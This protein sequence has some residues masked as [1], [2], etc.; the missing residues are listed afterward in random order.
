MPSDLT[1]RTTIGSWLQLADP[2][3]TEIM[4]RSGFDWLTIDLE[5]TSTTLAQAAEMIR[6]GSLAGVPMFA[7]ISGH[8]TDQIKRLLDMGVSGIIA[9]DVR[10]A[11]DAERLAAACFYPPRG[12]R[13]VGLARAQGY[14]RSFKQ[15]LEGSAND[16]VF[17]PQIEHIGAVD[18]LDGILD[19]DGVAGFFVGPYDLSGSLGLPGQFDH[20]DVQAALD[21]VAEFIRPTGP[22]AGI[23]VVDPDINQLRSAIKRGYRFI[24]FASEMLIFSE[25]MENLASGVQSVR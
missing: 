13:G 25:R 8:D 9:P 23:H 5:H 1:T 24:G 7:R 22:F 3:L 19:V 11:S 17:I 4:A 14:G 16:V 18:E 12:K 21:R 10:S 15:Y 20:P 6:I 2:N